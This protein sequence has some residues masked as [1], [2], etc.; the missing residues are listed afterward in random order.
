MP[1]FNSVTV[2]I[3][4]QDIDADIDFEVYCEKCGAGLCNNANTRS[5]HNRSMAQVTITPCENC[6]ENS[7]EDGRQ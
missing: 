5:S 2:K 7:Y 6:L 3:P 1:T 4:E